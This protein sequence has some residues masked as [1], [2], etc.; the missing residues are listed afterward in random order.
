MSENTDNDIKIDPGTAIDEFDPTRANSESVTTASE[1]SDERDYATAG[2]LQARFF[3]FR[4]S[5]DTEPAGETTLEELTVNIRSGK[6][7][8]VVCQS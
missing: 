3:A 8:L 2:I 5:F 1:R 4:N 6:W 7:R